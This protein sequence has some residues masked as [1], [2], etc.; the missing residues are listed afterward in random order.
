[1]LSHHKATEARGN[2]K[3]GI[4]AKAQRRRKA[5]CLHREGAETQRKIE[6]FLM[7]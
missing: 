2:T 3:S 7:L 4:T 6:R 1:M 5:K